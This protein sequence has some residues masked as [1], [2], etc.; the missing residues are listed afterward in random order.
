MRHRVIPAKAG[1]Q[2]AGI[3][4]GIGKRNGATNLDSRL[5]A[6][7]DSSVLAHDGGV[8]RGT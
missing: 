6:N 5:R 4:H 8:E 2:H 1:I 3:A 7:D